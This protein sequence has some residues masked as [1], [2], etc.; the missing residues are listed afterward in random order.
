[1]PR[2]A[3]V[4]VS[5]VPHHVTQRGNRGQDVF[6]SEEDRE[7]YLAW[8]GEYAAQHRLKIWAYCLMSN[9]VHYVVVPKKAS[10]LGDV[11]Q[12]LHTRHSQA[13]NAEQGWQ[14]HLWQGRFFSCPLDEAHL[15]ARRHAWL[16]YLFSTSDG[17]TVGGRQVTLR[18]LLDRTAE[19]AVA[20]A[21]GRPKVQAS[22]MENFADLYTALYLRETAAQW[23]KKLL[24]LQEK[25]LGNLLIEPEKH[26]ARFPKHL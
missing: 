9:H 17:V 24:D 16:A 25:V 10:A 7:R 1:M 5:G 21:H 4:V 15:A 14:G 19:K 3:R 6:F 26:A 8:L 22:L 12:S 11:M 18:D 2:V 23:R 20:N 13:I